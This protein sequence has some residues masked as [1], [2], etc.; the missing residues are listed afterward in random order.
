MGA[1]PWNAYWGYSAAF[2]IGGDNV[3]FSASDASGN[4]AYESPLIP[5]VRRVPGNTIPFHLRL[6][7]R[8]VLPEHVVPGGTRPTMLVDWVSVDVKYP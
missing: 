7:N 5:D 1:E 4:R 3:L 6:S 2:T 8:D